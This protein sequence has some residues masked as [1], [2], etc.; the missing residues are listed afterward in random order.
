MIPIVRT[1]A[2]LSLLCLLTPSPRAVR[3]QAVARRLARERSAPAPDSAGQAWSWLVSLN[4]GSMRFTGV[5]SEQAFGAVIL[6][7]PVDWL[8]LDINPVYA[9]AQTAPDSATVGGRTVSIPSRTLRGMVD[10]P[11]S[12]DARYAFESAWSP[13][14]GLSLGATLPTGDSTTVGVG[15]S[16]AGAAI[17]LDLSPSENVNLAIALEHDLFGDYGT[18][19]ANSARTAFSLGSTARLGPAGVGLSYSSSV[20]STAGATSSELLTG[21]IQ[22]DVIS[23][24]ALHASVARGLTSYSPTWSFGFGVM[25]FSADLRNEFSDPYDRLRETFGIGRVLTR[26]QVRRPRAPRRP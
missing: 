20:G 4:A 26:T 10:L 14:I 7:R 3:A 23:G 21:G 22:W 9:I 2:L 19:L 25:L 6:L 16:T 17:S 8:T 5:A 15:R 18:G 24:V 1:L 11:V 13:A 12:V